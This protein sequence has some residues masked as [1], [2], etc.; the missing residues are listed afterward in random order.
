MTTV[1]NG[2]ALLFCPG[3]RPDRYDKAVQRADAVLL[4]LEDAVG[5]ADKAVARD[6]VTAALPKLGDR[7]IVRVN[8]LDTEWHEEDVR[9]V[10]EAGVQVVMLPKTASAADVRSLSGLH[11]I[12]L[13]ETASGVL[14]AEEIAAEENCAALMWGGEDLIADIG[15]RNSRD[16]SGA[17]YAAIQ[18]ARST[19]L[20]AA[21]A[22]SKPAVDAVFADI[23]NLGSLKAECLEAV[24]LGFRAKACIHPSHVE[25]IRQAFAPNPEEVAWAEGLLREAENQG[26]AVFTFQGKMVDAPVYAHARRILESQYYAEDIASNS[27]SKQIGSHL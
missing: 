4:D 20:L 9:A 8:G 15:G 3:D 1:F 23:A 18:Q 24:D 7:A 21:A 12:A 2:P 25:T 14:R 16:S 19:V 13:C 27:S 22:A 11:V 6:L 17:Y 26:G 5:P 10:R